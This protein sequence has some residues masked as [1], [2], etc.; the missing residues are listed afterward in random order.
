MKNLLVLLVVLGLVATA[1][2]ASC[3]LS[4]DG[5]NAAPASDTIAVGST[6]NIAIL[7]TDGVSAFM[8]LE[9]DDTAYLALNMA[10]IYYHGDWVYT[11]GTVEGMTQYAAAG[12]MAS[13]QGPTQATA[14]KYPTGFAGFYELSGGGVP[15]TAPTAGKWFSINY[16]AMRYGDTYITLYSDPDGVEI[17]QMVVHQIPEPITMTLLGLGAVIVRKRRG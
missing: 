9:L 1:N 15:P 10:G 5:I 16:Q 11:G 7:S 13:I 4:L 8:D 2:A 14:G 3:V 17:D 12:G 6:I